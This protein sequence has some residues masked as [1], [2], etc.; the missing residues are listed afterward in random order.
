VAP[1]AAAA[2]IGSQ[3]ASPDSK[4]QGGGGERP[5]EGEPAQ[6]P[7]SAKQEG[8]DVLVQTVCELLRAAVVNA[9]AGHTHLS[10]PYASA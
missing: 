7:G 1:A 2:L 6:D 5:A 4:Q 10:R 8:G 9:L 3:P